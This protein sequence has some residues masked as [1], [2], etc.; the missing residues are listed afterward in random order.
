MNRMRLRGIFLFLSLGM[1]VATEVYAADEP[2]VFGLDPIHKTSAFVGLAYSNSIRLSA[3]DPDGDALSYSMDSG[4]DWLSV[5]NDGSLS[6]TPSVDDVGIEEVTVRVEDI[7][8]FDTAILSIPVLPAPVSTGRPN[9][10]YILADD[11]GYSDISAQG[12]ADLEFETPSIDAIFHEGMYF[13]AGFVSNSVCAPSRAGLMTGRMGSRFGFE[14]NFGNAIAGGVGSTIGLDPNQ[15][16]LA[17]VLKVA[18]YK[19]FCVGKWHLGENASLFHPNVRGFDEFFGLIGGSR[20]YTYLENPASDKEI[21]NNQQVVVEPPDLYVTDFFTD[22]AL[23]YIEEQTQNNP[24][25][26]WFMYMSYT[27]PHGPMDAKEIDISRV[28]LAAHYGSDYTKDVPVREVLKDGSVSTYKLR[29]NDA[30]RR[31]YGAMVLNMD[32]NVG[33]LLHKLGEL[34]IAENTLVIFHSDNGGPLRGANWSFNKGL[35]GAK[36]NLWEGGVRVPFAFQ[37]PGVIPAGQVGGMDLAVSSLDLMP[38]FAAI[39]GADQLQ[40]I[41]TDGMNLMPLLRGRISTL[42]ERQLFWRRGSTQ[43]ISTRSD[44]WKYYKNRN[45][46]DEYV[47]DHRTTAGEYGGNQV[48][49]NPDKLSELQAEY[50]A[51][52]ASIP[53]PH[54]NADGELLARN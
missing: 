9:V 32:D 27:A 20:N 44:G 34:G 53:D 39:S 38:T 2:P 14:S 46:G 54:W 18:G 48:I 19:T 26:P 6:G 23:D 15:K 30:L 12:W 33:R 5:G 37:W 24:D 51:F 17:D 50:A 42:P 36:G 47:F 7:D 11:L 10:L 22:K 41:H 52:E 49:T 16:T 21:R 35:R 25:Q 8:G 28:P 45:T 3:Y 1:S 31:I 43:Q 29:D 13:R 4:P 40:Q